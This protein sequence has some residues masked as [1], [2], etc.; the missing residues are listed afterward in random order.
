MLA[1]RD[2]PLEDARQVV[3]PGPRGAVFDIVVARHVLGGDGDFVGRV[4][5]E[6]PCGGQARD[7]CPESIVRQRNS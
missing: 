1:T 2:S 7:S 5:G 3:G 4:L 6:E